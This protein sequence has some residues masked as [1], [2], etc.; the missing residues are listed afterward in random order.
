[1]SLLFLVLLLVLA[2]AIIIYLW[3]RRAQP[4]VITGAGADGLYGIEFFEKDG[5]KRCK[6]YTDKDQK[7]VNE[8][9]E[10]GCELIK[11]LIAKTKEILDDL[12]KT[13]SAEEL[14][15]G[16]SIYRNQPSRSVTGQRGHALS[17][18]WSMDEYNDKGFQY[19]YIKNKSIQRYTETYDMLQMAYNDGWRLPCPMAEVKVISVGGG[20]GFELLA[21]KDFCEKHFPRA[22]CKFVS[23]DLAPT[24]RPYV[25]A[26]GFE[27]RTGDVNSDEAIALMQEHDIVIFSY[28]L[29]HYAPVGLINRIWTKPGPDVIFVNTRFGYNI[30]EDEPG[31]GVNYR[32]HKLAKKHY[33]NIYL[34]PVRQ[35]R[36]FASVNDW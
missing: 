18:T 23:M 36:L 2:V 8:T 5:T 16:E 19:H 32:V 17:A 7:Y 25:E 12:E 29:K 22:K 9:T 4:A 34:T 13:L 26:L 24:W 28:V 27:F 6:F 21:F 3:R 30:F 10:E 35:E 1:M 15:K 11:K 20:P 31:N 33:R 14:A